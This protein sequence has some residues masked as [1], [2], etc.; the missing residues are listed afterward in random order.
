MDS[1]SPQI[2]RIDPDRP[3]SALLDPAL[4]ALARGELVI[5]PTETVYGLAADP[6]N[7]GAMQR[8]FEAKGRSRVKPVTLMAADVRQVTRHGGIL[9]PAAKALA[10]AYWPGPLTLVLP[11]GDGTDGFRIPGYAVT[12]ELLRKAGTVLAVTSANASGDPPAQTAAEAV[13]VLGSWVTVALDAG[14]SPGGVP[15]TVVRVVGE[16]VEILR[17]GAISK[18]DVLRVAGS[19][20]S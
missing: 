6:R 16:T 8:L 11:T 13:R 10:D 12:L 7:A 19:A 9:R 18:K 15:S 4:K 2:L 17:A 20:G 14:P 3:V 1:P 5:V